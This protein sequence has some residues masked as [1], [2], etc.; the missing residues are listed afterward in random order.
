VP[1]K[2]GKTVDRVVRQ[3]P[4]GGEAVAAGSVV[5]LDVNVGPATARLPDDLVGQDVEDATQELV[6]AGFTR[7]RSEA[8]RGPGGDAAAGT[9]LSVD[10]REGQ[11]VALDEDVLLRYARPSSNP[12]ASTRSRAG[13]ATSASATPSSAPT[14]SS[15]PT[16]PARTATTA[17]PTRPTASTSTAPP[18]P[19]RTPQPTATAK[20]TA[21]APPT[22]SSSPSKKAKRSK[23]PK[24]P[25]NG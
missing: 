1:G 4:G 12:A 19:T 15:S 21:T 13:R 6:A 22:A 18:Q 8:V 3:R 11:S 25:K 5:T 20:P 23:K 14:R 24:P 9:V 17:P 7:V 10:P 16:Q 2:A